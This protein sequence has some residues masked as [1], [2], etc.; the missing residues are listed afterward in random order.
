LRHRLC[1]LLVLAAALA[2]PGAASASQLIDRNATGVTLAV[3][4]QSEALVSY[5]SGGKLEHVLAWGAINARPP[6]R[7]GTQVAFQL[8]YAGGYGKYHRDY[9][10]TFVDGCRAYDGPPLPWL[11]AAC[12]APDGSYWALQSWQR[13]LPNYGVA[14]TPAQAA[15]ELHLSHWRGPLPLLV[16][17]TDWAYR[18]RFDHLYGTLS[19]AGNAVFGFRS[20]SHGQPLDSWGRNVVVDTLDS[21]YGKGWKRENSFLVHR[22]RGNFCYGFYVHRAGLTG[23]GTRYRATVMGPGVTPLV[24]WQGTAPGRYAEAAD[25]AAN[26]EQRAWHDPLCKVT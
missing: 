26:D 2:A 5:R 24:M 3:D 12:T 14:P 13:L 15:W 8:D 20:T 1:T 21:A 18:G 10:T 9:A 16:V 7:T 25:A 11:V 19:Y 4:A 17:K 23:K 22:P 6:V